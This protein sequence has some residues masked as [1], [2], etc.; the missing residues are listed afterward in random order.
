MARL[1]IV[2]QVPRSPV[3]QINS[4]VTM[5]ESVA[6]LSR[7]LERMFDEALRAIARFDELMERCYP[8]KTPESAGLV[9]GI[10]AFTRL[11]NRA[12]AAQLVGIGQLFGYRLARCSENDDWAMDTMAAVAAERGVA[13]Q[14]GHGRKPADIC[15]RDART[16]AQCG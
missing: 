15:A 9:E 8:S 7:L 1:L 16:V 6:D 13:D 12:V 10:C 5:S 14:S 3:G 11:E 4:K 2:F